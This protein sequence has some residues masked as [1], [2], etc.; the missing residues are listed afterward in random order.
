VSQK[1]GRRLKNT[2]VIIQYH[3]T[4]LDLASLMGVLGNSIPVVRCF[5]LEKDGETFADTV[6][7][8]MSVASKFEVLK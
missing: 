5:G 3:D 2:V 8:V 1:T 7:G 6:C 4:S